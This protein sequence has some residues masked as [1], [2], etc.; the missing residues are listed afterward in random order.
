MDSRDL[1]LMV[2]AG[3]KLE[4]LDSEVCYLVELL[5]YMVSK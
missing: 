1:N 2:G 4:K 3:L 5:G